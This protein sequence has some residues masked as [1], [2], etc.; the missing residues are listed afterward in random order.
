ML[1]SLA[2]L[3]R[4]RGV[5]LLIVG[6]ADLLVI[7][8]LVL[9][10][11]WARE[12]YRLRLDMNGLV[13]TRIRKDRLVLRHG[14]KVRIVDLR[15]N[16]GSRLAPGRTRTW[17]LLRSDGTTALRLYPDRWDQQELSALRERLQAD[18]EV[19][20]GLKTPRWLRK[21]FPGSVPW[22]LA[23]VAASTVIFILGLSL[24]IALLFPSH[25]S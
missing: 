1:C 14:E 12:N 4:F 3:V 20:D 25:H 21:N 2:F 11:R 13:L 9:W 24:L 17:L 8:W 19:V 6:M 15:V 7:A 23:H 10:G 5:W 22:V 16:Y 18:V